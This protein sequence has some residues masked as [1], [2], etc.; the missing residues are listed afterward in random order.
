[1]SV[2]Y[3]EVL[4]FAHCNLLHAKKKRNL[5]AIRRAS[6]KLADAYPEL[7]YEILKLRDEN[8]DLRLKARIDGCD[9]A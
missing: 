5:D 1:M 6:I 2:D 8:E 9:D 4:D 3:L 7:R